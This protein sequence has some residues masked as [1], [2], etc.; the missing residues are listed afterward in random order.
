MTPEGRIKKKIIDHFKNDPEV[1]IINKFQGKYGSAVGVSDLLCNIKGIFLAMEVKTPTGVLTRPQE[2]FLKR[3]N[4]IGGLGIVVKSLDDA[5]E[6]ISKIK[7]MFK[8]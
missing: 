8:K 1:M 6:I 2:L 5:K 4:N 7:D 3:T